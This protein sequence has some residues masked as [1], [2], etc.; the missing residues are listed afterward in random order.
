MSDPMTTQDILVA[1]ARIR[2][3]KL[4]QLTAIRERL[5]QLP[6]Q[7]DK[8]RRDLQE[9]TLAKNTAQG[10]LDRLESDIAT[11]VRDEFTVDGEKMK[12]KYSN[13]SLRNAETARRLSKHP[14]Y[15]AVT[16]AV[17]KA[18]AVKWNAQFALNRLEDEQVSTH[19]SLQAIGIEVQILSD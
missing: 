15:G 14:D 11:E 19:K 3:A 10:F 9:A 5:D 17:A 13:D 12:P 4:A 8:A 16:E 1:A 6:L 2:Y 7:L 18:E